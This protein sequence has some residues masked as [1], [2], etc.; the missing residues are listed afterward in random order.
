MPGATP[1][2]VTLKGQY[3]RKPAESDAKTNL[4]ASATGEYKRHE[5]GHRHVIKAG[6]RFEAGETGG[7]YH[8]HISLACPWAN[9]VLSMLYLKGLEHVISHSVVHPTWGKT[10]PDQPEDEHYGWVYR[11]PGDPPMANVLGHGS[12]PCDDAN[13]PDSVT[14]ATS[15]RE[16]YEK[17]GDPSGPFTTPVLWDTK[18]GTIVNN[19][20]SE[21]L[22]M[23]NSEFNHLAKHPEVDLYPTEHE[24]MLAELNSQTVYPKINNGVYRSGF[25]RTQEAYEKAVGELFEGLDQVEALLSKTRFLAGEHLTWL[26]VRLF[27][28]LVRFDPVYAIYFKTVKSIASDFP[29]LLGFI[30]DVYSVPAIRRSLNFAHFQTHYFTSHPHLNT[31]AIIPLSTGP[32]LEV[33]SGRGATPASPFARVPAK[34]AVNAS[35]EEDQSNK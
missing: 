16:V 21:I 17:A 24:A 1:A 19:E 30:R 23:L 3:D 29:N 31:F 9:G 22:R 7:R 34:G 8:L 15:I 20:S 14:N 4:R 27:H 18:E 35:A 5:S 10:K 32:D 25:A 2:S 13:V 12:V 33:P 26:D 11:K 6:T 28:T